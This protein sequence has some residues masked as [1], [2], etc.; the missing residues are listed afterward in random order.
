M[1]KILNIHVSGWVPGAIYIGRKK[2]SGEHFGNPFE[3][4]KDGTR[5]E[6]CDMFEAWLAGKAFKRVEPE[7]RQWILDNLSML[8][9]KKLLCFC[10]PLRCHGETLRRLAKEKTHD[11]KM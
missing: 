10:A 8:A 6:V 3:I 7:R 11:K 1:A 2:K 9:N 5:D 4:G